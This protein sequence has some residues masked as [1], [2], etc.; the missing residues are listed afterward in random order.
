MSAGISEESVL[1]KLLQNMNS[2]APSRRARLRELTSTED[3]HYTGRDGREYSMAKGELDRIFKALRTRGMFDVRLPI[4]LMADAGYE[5]SVWTV[6][7]EEECA[8]VAEVLGRREWETRSRLHLY[9][10]HMAALRRELPT[11]TVCLYLP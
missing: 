11:T 4:V 10:P 8:V 3:P 1:R 2:G 9:G 6:E 7:G 5:Q